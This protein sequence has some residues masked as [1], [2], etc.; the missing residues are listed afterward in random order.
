MILDDFDW[1]RLINFKQLL[2]CQKTIILTDKY[3]KKKTLVWGKPTIY[4]CN[5]EEDPFQICNPKYMEWLRENCV[6]VHI[7]NKLY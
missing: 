2:G 4:I 1:D 3:T 7:R 6:K 5:P